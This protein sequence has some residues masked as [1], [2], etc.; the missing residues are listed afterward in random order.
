MPSLANVKTVSEIVSSWVGLVALIAG[1][2]F[3][4][5]QYLEKERGDRVKVTL[6]FLERQNITPVLEARR[7]LLAKWRPHQPSLIAMLARPDGGVAD[8]NAFVLTVIKD[9]EL[10]EDVVTVMDYY[11]SLQIC[12]ESKVCD[13]TTTRALFQQDAKVFF[14]LHYP[15][16]ADQK[17]ERSDPN[18]GRLLQTFARST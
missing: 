11:E 16:I 15:F 17:K 18:F 4:V 6:D 8:F 12:V 3:G 9:E 10:F 13:A 2:A 1:G 14:N 5:V 7:N